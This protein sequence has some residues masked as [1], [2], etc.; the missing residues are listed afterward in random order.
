LLIERISALGEVV[1][2]SGFPTQVAIGLLL[3]GAGVDMRAPDGGLS[4]RYVVTLWVIDSLVVSGLI[5]A[6]L[7]LRGERLGALLIG[8]RPIAR[9]MV[10]GLALVPVILLLANGALLA[11]RLAWPG[12]HNVV[13]N[14]FETLIRSR[15]DAVALA[16]LAGLAGLK[17]EFQRAFVLRRFER[18]LGGAAIGLMVFSVVF[19]AGHV[20]QGWD[21]AAVTT[22]LG[23]LWGVVYLR[24]GNFAASAI[25]HSGFNVAQIVQ[26][27]ILGT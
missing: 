22:L 9:E 3:A 13:V 19:G 12:L 5:V 24:R 10:L 2:T 20:I 7:S 26:F 6:L 11:V 21:A 8:R 17:E 23:C 25:S 14:P 27:V 18:H 15:G 4:L 1:L 16:V